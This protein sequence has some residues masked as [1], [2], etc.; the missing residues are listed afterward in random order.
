MNK[1]DRKVASGAPRITF[2]DPE[3]I[4]ATA[5][6]GLRQSELITAEYDRTVEEIVASIP[7]SLSEEDKLATLYAFFLDKMTY[8][9]DTGNN[10]GSSGMVSSPESSMPNYLHT[11]GGEELRLALGKEAALLNGFGVCSGFSDAFKD[12]SDR[13]GIPCVVAEGKTVTVKSVTGKEV[14]LGHAWI[15]VLVD[16]EVLNI[17]PT[18][19]LFANDEVVKEEKGLA[20]ELTAM[21]FFLVDSDTLRNIGPHHDFEDSPELQAGLS[22]SA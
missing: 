6:E 3:K 15:Q 13:L 8:D 12:V 7:E 19:G 22:H 11:I 18:Y 16:G 2:L 9:F 17:D 1:Y 5:A 14:E 21:D 20:P 10:V 4:A